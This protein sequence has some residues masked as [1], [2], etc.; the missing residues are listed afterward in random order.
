[1]LLLLTL[2]NRILNFSSASL[3]WANGLVC[4]WHQED[5]KILRKDMI[6]S[7]LWSKNGDGGGHRFLRMDSKE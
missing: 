2:L 1:V 6:T 5:H 4:I 7:L 3:G